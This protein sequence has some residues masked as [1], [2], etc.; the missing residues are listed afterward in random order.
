MPRK[1]FGE[2]P[3]TV[4]PVPYLKHIRLNKTTYGENAPSRPPRPLSNLPR[5]AALLFFFS[6]LPKPFSLATYTIK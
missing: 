2:Y 4:V 6:L 1:Y 3:G 5:L